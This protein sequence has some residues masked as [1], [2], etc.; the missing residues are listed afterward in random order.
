MPLSLSMQ[1]SLSTPALRAAADIQLSHIPKRVT[2]HGVFLAGF[3]VLPPQ[4]KPGQVRVER[5]MYSEEAKLNEETYIETDMPKGSV[6]TRGLAASTRPEDY[7]NPARP[8][9]P[10]EP[11]EGFGH[12]KVSHWKSTSASTH[13]NDALHGAVY[14]RQH[15]PSY[16]ALNPPTCVGRE[17]DVSLYGEEY[18]HYGSDPRNKLV[19]G[20]SKMPVFKSALTFGTPKGTEHMPG[21]QGFLPT[22]TSNPMVARVESG[23]TLRSTDKTNLTAQ[24]HVNLLGYSGH[25]PLNLNNQP[26]QGVRANTI[27]DYG[28]SFR[29]PPP[30]SVL[31]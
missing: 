26:D 27:T 21:Y 17:V 9:K 7:Q 20:S 10:G 28:R 3:E 23:R 19:P 5:Q 16:Q 30:A 2:Q 29:K 18:G 12:H 8:M 25:E 4:L 31:G 24:F 13:N 1:K 22:N 15:G 11:A 14:N 6:Y